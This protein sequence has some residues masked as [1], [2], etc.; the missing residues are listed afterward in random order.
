MISPETKE[1][2]FQL[3]D[4]IILTRETLSE[5]YEKLLNTNFINQF[6]ITF[7]HRCQI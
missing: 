1:E 4:K 7:E 2:I 5:R 6:L 3:F